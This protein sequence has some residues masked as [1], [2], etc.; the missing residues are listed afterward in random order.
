M[1][2]GL[3]GFKTRGLDSS[4]RTVRSPPI[5]RTTPLKEQWA[6]PIPAL[7]DRVP[8]TTRLCA[9]AM[10]HSEDPDILK[11]PL[12]FMVP[13][14]RSSRHCGARSVIEPL[15]DR[16]AGVR[17]TSRY[18][19]LAEPVSDMFRAVN[20]EALTTRLATRLVR[21]T[22]ASSTTDPLEASSRH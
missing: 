21:A 9:I 4:P 12:T 20:V 5:C 11:L 2:L 10:P 13:S 18:I 17:P 14:S 16:L 19:V 6:S 3:D 1:V 15:S 7:M 8:P 22:S